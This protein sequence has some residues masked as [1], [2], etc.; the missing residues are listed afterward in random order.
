MAADTGRI[1]RNEMRPA[2]L[3]LDTNTY[4]GFFKL[5]GDDLEE[6]EKLA[7][8]VRSAGTVLYITDQV[9]DEFLRQRSNV[10]RESL[11][12]V[13]DSR[14]PAS[15]PRLLVNLD[16]YRELRDALAE[17]ER[18]R[19]GLLAEANREARDCALKADARIK[20]LFEL[21]SDLGRPDEAV[22]RARNRRDLGNP[23][24]KGDFIGD[25][26]NWEILLACVPDGEDVVIVTADKDYRSALD[27]TALDE[28]LAHEWSERKASTLSLH[29]SLSALFKSRYPHI[30][31][32]AELE[33]E[34]AINRLIAS[35]SYGE[36]HLAIANLENF[37]DYSP[38]Q[39]RA[40]VDAAASNGQIGRILTDDDV[41]RFYSRI[42]DRF[43]GHLEPQ[44][45]AW[46]RDEIEEDLPF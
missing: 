44:A 6:L 22:V 10:I 38:D 35:G 4:L 24:G 28:F 3:F 7:V 26:V 11:K 14:L 39:V 43:A 21:A 17:Y 30:K 1:A 41:K 45:L 32:A 33:R 46:L 16:G 40:I 2:R 34:L 36:T 13:E 8:A 20:E 42:I 37:A 5:S 25:A 15:F 23:P 31:L 29:T 12:Y 19:S 18:Q 9:R 27:D